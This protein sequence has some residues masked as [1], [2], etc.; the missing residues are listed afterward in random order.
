MSQDFCAKRVLIY[1]QL[2]IGTF[3]FHPPNSK[4]LENIIWRCQ[5]VVVEI[6]LKLCYISALHAQLS[7][8]K[9]K[10]KPISIVEVVTYKVLGFLLPCDCSEFISKTSLPLCLYSHHAVIMAASP[11]PQPWSPLWYWASSVSTLFLEC[12]LSL[13]AAKWSC[14]YYL[15]FSIPNQQ[16]PWGL[17]RPLCFSDKEHSPWNFIFFKI[18]LVCFC[19]SC[20]HLKR[21]CIDLWSMWQQ[22]NPC[23]VK[24]AH[25][26]KICSFVVPAPYSVE[27][28]AWERSPRVFMGLK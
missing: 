28:S 21:I 26:H 2:W 16:G 10:G 20:M 7:S 15:H 22:H 25:E 17:F 23:T 1:S 13:T 27:I 19:K 24:K 4:G 6:W 3:V 8:V 14:S 18:A 11:S 12:M 5:S 9:I